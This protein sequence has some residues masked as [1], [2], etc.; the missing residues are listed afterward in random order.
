MEDSS[1]FDVSCGGE[2]VSMTPYQNLLLLKSKLQSLNVDLSLSF[3]GD[4]TFVASMKEGS[5]SPSHY[6]IIIIIFCLIDLF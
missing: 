4:N 3:D 5:E 6:I 1:N 2:S